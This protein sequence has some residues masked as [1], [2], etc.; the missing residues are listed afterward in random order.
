MKKYKPETQNIN[1]GAVIGEGCT[2][3]S[4]VSI[5]ELVTVGMR[6]KIEAYAFL[7]N[8]VTLEDDV[9]I[10]PHVCFTNDPKLDDREDYMTPTLVKTGAK[11]GAN[12]TILAGI[13]I[14]E[15]SIIGCGSVVLKDVKP[16]SK[17]AGNPAKEI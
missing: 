5:H 15:H 8:G 16:Y 11:I 3:H 6:C 14:G 13:T 10:G 2:I 7:P 4:H 9:F 1:P 17:V 12:S